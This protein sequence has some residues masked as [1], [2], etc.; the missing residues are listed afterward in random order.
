MVKWKFKN[1]QKKGWKIAGK[2]KG[3][4][5]AKKP[6][7]GQVIVVLYYRMGVACLFRKSLKSKNLQL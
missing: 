7:T 3:K 2:C 1:C 6:I 5:V 4:K